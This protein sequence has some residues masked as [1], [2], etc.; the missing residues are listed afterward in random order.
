MSVECSIECVHDAA[1]PGWEGQGY[2]FICSPDDF[3]MSF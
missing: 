3:N 1:G 2:L